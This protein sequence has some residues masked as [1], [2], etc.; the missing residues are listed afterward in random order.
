MVISVILITFQATTEELLFRGYYLQGVAWATNR[1]WSAIVLTSIIFGLL[2][3]ANPEIEAYGW[4]YVMGYILM[5][6]ATGVLTVM[7]DGSELAIGLHVVNNLYAAIVVGFPASVL[8]TNTLFF[9]N[10]YIATY[11]SIVG[12]ISLLIFLA[13]CNRKYGWESFRAIFEKLEE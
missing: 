6:M 9:V 7:D 12:V 2:H 1:P 11:W 8:Q 5:G 4:P 13:I 3:L 10:D